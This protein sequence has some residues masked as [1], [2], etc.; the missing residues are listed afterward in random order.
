MM[1]T[2]YEVDASTV[3]SPKQFPTFEIGEMLSLDGRTVE[4]LDLQGWNGASH[5]VALIKDV[6]GD[7]KY[8]A[9]PM[10]GSI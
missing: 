10:P 2:L 3:E 4:V 9:G 8:E 7:A 6:H 1:S 5:A